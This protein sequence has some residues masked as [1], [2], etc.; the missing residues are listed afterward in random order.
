M[1]PERK[2][3]ASRRLCLFSPECVQQV[4]PDAASTKEHSH[5]WGGRKKNGFGR[6]FFFSLTFNGVI[7]DVF[8]GHGGGHGQGVTSDAGGDVRD[9]EGQSTAALLVNESG[10][11]AALKMLLCCPWC[12]KWGKE[13]KKVFSMWRSESSSFVFSLACKLLLKLLTARSLALLKSYFF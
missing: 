9:T 8:V 3:K 13:Q 12:P 6:V 4:C 10:H 11:F 1:S 5:R 7:L 2:R